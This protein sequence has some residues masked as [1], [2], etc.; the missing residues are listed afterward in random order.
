MLVKNTINA[1]LGALL[2][3]IAA[4]VLI[5][6]FVLQ[7]EIARSGWSSIHP[8]DIFIGAPVYA[9]ATTYWIL[10]VV[11]LLLGVLIPLLVRKKTRREALICGIVAGVIVGLV[12]GCLLAYDFAVGTS[13]S[14]DDSVRWWGRFWG[15]VASSALLSIVYCSIWTSAYAF[16]K[17][18][19]GIQRSP[20]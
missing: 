18:G 19:A 1:L 2:S 13:N 15:D 11:G 7:N 9:L 14:A 3:L 17:A 4:Y 8:M 5:V 12:F 10:I 16:I 6:T 20:P